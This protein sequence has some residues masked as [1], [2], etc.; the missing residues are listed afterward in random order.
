VQQLRVRPEHIGQLF[1]GKPVGAA[2]E[3]AAGIELLNTDE[4][5]R[6]RQVTGADE[7]RQEAKLLKVPSGPD[8]GIR[9]DRL[10]CPVGGSDAIL[11]IQ[12]QNPPR[13]AFRQVSAPGFPGRL[14]ATEFGK[15]F[16]KLFVHVNVLLESGH[17][18]PHRQ[19]EAQP[20]FTVKHQYHVCQEYLWRTLCAQPL[21]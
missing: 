11:P 19:S 3:E 15:L 21:R 20:C 6:E 10:N 12:Q 1:R 2:E 17:E 18:I 16:P 8:A 7:V 13:I 14:L 9:P 4:L 5:A